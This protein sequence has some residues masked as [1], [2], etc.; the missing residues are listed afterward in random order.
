MSRGWRCTQLFLL[1]IALFI[2]LWPTWPPIGD[3]PQHAA[4][5]AWLQRFAAGDTGPL[6]ELFRVNFA[7]PYLVGYGLTWL[8]A[9]VVSIPVALKLVLVGY[10][11]GFVS[12][13]ELLLREV[14]S[15]PR[16]TC[17]VVPVALG[18]PYQ[19]GFLNYL[20]G[21]PLL[22]LTVRS[23]L[24]FTRTPS[25]GR[26]V[27]LT[28]VLAG[29]VPVHA[30]ISLLSGAIGGVMALGYPAPARRRALVALPFFTPLPILWLWGQATRGGEAMTHA[31]PLWDTL[32][33][34]PAHL[35]VY[36][37]AA[38]RSM[39]AL[40]MG[41]V[42]L[43]LPFV[44][45][46]RPTETLWRWFPLLGLCTLV[47]TVPTFVFGTYFVW[48]RLAP[49]VFVFWLFVLEPGS[50]PRSRAL[51]ALVGV[52]PAA[53]L[54]HQASVVVA[55]EEEIVELRGALADL[56]PDQRVLSLVFDRDGV[57]QGAAYMHLS[58]WYVVEQGGLVEMSFAQ[59]YPQMVRYRAGNDPGFPVGFDAEPGLFDPATMGGERWNWFLLR[60][61]RD[62]IGEVF[63]DETP[64][65][66]VSRSGAWWLYQREP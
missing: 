65:A 27:L 44:L 38:E 32:I 25:V 35:M 46:A 58:S 50:V 42:I 59:Y 48:E 56:P 37:L 64:P 20:V 1:S 34:R 15:D 6:G 31:P 11:V 18:L 57:A 61:D 3:L 49:L 43:T 21:L 9:N 41:I 4:Q 5:V 12:S 14:G 39:P 2:I 7:T 17:L 62:R 45:G 19:W 53:W 66:L 8:I 29:L 26:G 55:F 47:A 52:L 16:W 10:V 54:L 51:G 24:R 23:A 36:F 33:H 60:A 13:S 22:L 63:T 28:V 30:L 40:G